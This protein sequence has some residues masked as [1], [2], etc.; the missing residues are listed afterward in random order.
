MDTENTINPVPENEAKP[1]KGFPLLPVL[2]GGGIVLIAAIVALVIWLTGSESYQFNVPE[3]N[4][5]QWA[6]NDDDQMVFLFNGDKTVKIDDKLTA[7]MSDSSIRTDY[8]RLY[9]IWMTEGE[10]SDAGDYVYGDLYVVNQEKYVKAADEVQSFDLSP[11]GSTYV[12]LTDGDL[13]FGQ[14]SDPGKATKLDSEVSQIICVSPDGNTVAYAKTVKVTDGEEDEETEQ[15]EYYLSV[16]GAKGT[17]YEKKGAEIIAVSDGGNYVYYYKDAKFYV[18]DT[19]LA[20]TE[21]LSSVFQSYFGL[22]LAFNRDGSQVMYSALNSEDKT[23]VYLS[24]HAGDKKAVANGSLGMLLTPEES[25]SYSFKAGFF[26][27]N[28]T[29]SFAQTAVL[30]AESN[31]DTG[32]LDYNYYYLTNTQGDAEKISVLKNAD[33]LKMLRDGSTVMYIKSGNLR[34]INIHQPSSEPIEFVGSEEDIV[35]YGCT[36]DGKCIYVLDE[37]NNLYYVNNTTTMTRIKYDVIN[38]VVTA[39]GRVYFVNED[40]ELYYATPNGDCTKVASD[41]DSDSLAYDVYADVATIEIDGTFGVLNEERFTK[42]F[43]LN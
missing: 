5:I 22:L 40:N 10:Y 34:S 13:Y 43:V 31:A 19:K 33:D 2:I 15:T 25:S 41:V 26:V 36:P 12:Y 14:L 6:I 17:K 42:I 30:V 32:D 11:F 29:E 4:H 9:A 8:N 27:Y 38:Y 39:D 37:D 35:S 3:G 16:E 23:K 20:D 24:D 21:D 7:E 18:N 1:K 28:N